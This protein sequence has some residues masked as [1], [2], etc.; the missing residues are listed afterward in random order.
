MF[1]FCAA[2]TKSRISLSV[3]LGINYKKYAADGATRNVNPNDTSMKNEPNTK[4]I[5]KTQKKI[6]NRVDKIAQ[7]TTIDQN[8]DKLWEHI[9]FLN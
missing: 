4:T 7:K 6:C 1:M 8:D 3:W 2:L 5:K 9:F